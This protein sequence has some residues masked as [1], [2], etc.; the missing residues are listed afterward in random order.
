[1]ES[2]PFNLNNSVNPGDNL[3]RYV[4]DAWI[5]DHPV[6][7]NK[8]SYHAFLEV[9]DK[10]DDQLHILFDAEKGNYTQGN[11]SLIGKFYSSGMDEQAIERDGLTPLTDELELIDAMRT[12]EDLLN[13]SIYLLERGISPL[14]QYYAYQDPTNTSRVIPHLEQG[15]LGLPDRDY[16]FRNDSES[17]KMQDAY[18]SHIKKVFLL[19][20]FTQY[21]AEKN[22]GIVYSIE[23][24]IA[25]SHYTAVENRDAVNTTHILEWTSLKET[26]PDFGW[27]H[28]ITIAGSGVCDQVNVHQV[29]VISRLNTMLRTVAI[30]DWKVFFKYKLIDS[31]S[32]YLSSPYENEHFMFYEQILNGVET[33][34]PRWKRVLSTVNVLLCDEV[35]KQYVQRY[36]D[37]GSRQRVQNISHSIRVTLG[38]RILNLTWMEDTTKQAA[39][40]KLDAM[41]EK[42]GYPDAW[43][44]YSV[45]TLTDIYVD[46]VLEGSRYLIIHGPAGLDKIGKPV[47]RNTWLMSPQTVNAYYSR[48]LNE[49]VFPA[50]ILQPPF[51]N[52]DL[53]DSI[54]YGGI[55]TVIGHE[56]THG[57][58]D[59]GR[60][61]DKEG[62][63]K[64]WWSATDSARFTEQADLIVSQ[65]NQFEALPGLYID[66]NLTLGENIADFG[67]LTLAWHAWKNS[68]QDADNTRLYGN[69][70]GDQQLFLSFAQ[71]W[72]GVA[73]DEYIRTKTYTDRH[74]WGA[75]RA[76]GAPFNIPELYD[77]FPDITPN[78]ALYR[79]PDERPII[80]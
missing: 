79:T 69:L 31:T 63:L 40:D 61:Y 30:N 36:F 68:L 15:G 20:N 80:W 37:A 14:Y 11:D 65:Y 46:N 5:R 62:N 60:R 28:L 32:P 55:G 2:G 72:R 42:I 19:M 41:V 51:F 71:I 53:D 57:F 3:F 35:G 47:D 52:P 9:E 29:P 50:A 25:E 23:K 26:Y 7:S 21:E 44:D 73:R 49:I 18:M 56:M 24:E 1:M 4:N 64:D 74:P 45:L 16:Y 13:M 75:F 33:P 77:A 76:N 22:A 12:S 27:D 66:G 8:S 17:L 54:N 59:Q 38:E 78:N 70:T 58:D 10:T 39:K 6:P 34:E 48:T 43:M 67:G